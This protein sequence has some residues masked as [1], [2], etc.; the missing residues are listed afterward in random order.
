MVML[1]RTVCCISQANVPTKSI[2]TNA[3]NHA[4]MPSRT[5]SCIRTLKNSEFFLALC[6]AKMSNT[7]NSECTMTL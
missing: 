4:T 3:A 5:C 7:N 2:T 1:V 6:Q